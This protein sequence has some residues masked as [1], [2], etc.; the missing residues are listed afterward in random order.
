MRG[1]GGG[2]SA[3]TSV[4]GRLQPYPGA[5][6]TPS[7]SPIQAL[8]E[9]FTGVS[10]CRRWVPPFHPTRARRHCLPTPGARP[11]TSPRCPVTV[12]P[13]TT[14]LSESGGGGRGQY[15]FCAT[16]RRIT[17]PGSYPALC[18]VAGFLMRACT[19]PR[20]P[21]TLRILLYPI[22]ARRASA[23]AAGTENTE[24]ERRRSSGI[25]RRAEAPVVPGAV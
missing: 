7:R 13:M 11:T 25:E 14:S 6:G 12:R 4:A 16:F 23:L 24:G 2:H 20:P 9:R 21:D 22:R 3:T 1:T 8:L 18:P 10:P 17:P 15:R 19:R 5:G